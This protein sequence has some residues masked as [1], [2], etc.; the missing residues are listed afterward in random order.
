MTILPFEKIIFDESTNNAKLPFHFLCP[1]EK[2]LVKI[3]MPIS[4]E[5][6]ASEIKNVKTNTT[7]LVSKIYEV[8]HSLC[9]AMLRV[10]L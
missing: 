6:Q 3:G 10:A 5:S 7:G 8:D 2:L 1:F 9:L 4:F